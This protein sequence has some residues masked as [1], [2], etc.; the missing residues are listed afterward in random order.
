MIRRP[1]RSTLFPYTTLFRSTATASASGA[2]TV[3][4]TASVDVVRSV[5]LVIDKAFQNTALNATRLYSSHSH[6][7]Y[8]DFSLKAEGVHVTDTV[9]ARLAVTRFSDVPGALAA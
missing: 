7:S 2:T 3:N 6:L 5:A 9:D 8:D 1:P 4:D